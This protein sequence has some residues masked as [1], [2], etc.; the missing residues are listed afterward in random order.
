MQNSNPKREAKRAK[1]AKLIDYDRLYSFKVL[2]RLEQ[3]SNHRQRVL[4]SAPYS[5]LALFWQLVARKDGWSADQWAWPSCLRLDVSDL[6]E[7]SYAGYSLF[8]FVR[9]QIVTQMRSA[10]FENLFCTEDSDFMISCSVC[11]PRAHAIF[12]ALTELLGRRML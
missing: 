11:S 1:D 2:Q 6:L 8:L 10:P 5:T 7:I 4:Q 12:D 3:K 9:R